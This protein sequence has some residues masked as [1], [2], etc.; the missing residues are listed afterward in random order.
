MSL[1]DI[2]SILPNSN[3]MLLVDIG[4]MS[5]ISRHNLGGSPSLFGARLFDNCQEMDFRHFKICNNDFELFQF[6]L[7]GTLLGILAPP[8]IK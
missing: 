2:R 6:L 8:K 1:K 7:S 5:K 4:P 3:F